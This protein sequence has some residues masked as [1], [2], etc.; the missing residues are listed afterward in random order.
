LEDNPESDD[1]LRG[2]GDAYLSLGEHAKAVA[3]YEQA[4][5][6]KDQRNEP[7]AGTIN[8]LAWVLSTSPKPEVRN[9]KRAI[10][11]GTR[12]C[13]LIKYD[14]SYAVSTL[15]AAYAESGDFEKAREWAAKA[16]ELGEKE[17]SESLDNLRRE[18]EGYQKNKPWRELL[19]EDLTGPE[20]EEIRGAKSGG[21]KAEKSAKDESNQSKPAESDDS[22]NES[23]KNSES[24][25]PEKKSDDSNKGG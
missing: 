10:E 14:E 7:D 17:Q 9:G 16:V 8:N 6:I 18:L 19:S 12:A 3:D 5:E 24:P 15:A 21:D 2:R 23:D 11:L 22:K 13:E 20:G 1:A 4:I 25:A